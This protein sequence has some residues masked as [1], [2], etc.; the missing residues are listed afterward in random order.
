MGQ[1]TNKGI[2]TMSNKLSIDDDKV[3]RD[4]AFR[5]VEEQTNKYK[6]GFDI[7]N[8]N[9]N[10]NKIKKNTKIKIKS[11]G[12]ETKFVSKLSKLF[13]LSFIQ[14]IK[15]KFQAMLI[16]YFNRSFKYKPKF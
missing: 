15:A 11:K 14:D 12:N 6:D 9:K 8:S 3:E 13:S 2:L 16:N 7:E 1:K 10:G 5:N 4:M